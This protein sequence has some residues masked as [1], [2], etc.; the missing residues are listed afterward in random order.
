MKKTIT[1]NEFVRAFDDMN[2]EDQFTPYAREALFDYLE[3]LEQ[4]CGVPEIELDVIALCCEYTQYKNIE[5]YNIAYGSDFQ[6]FDELQDSGDVDT[7][8]KVG[9]GAIVD[10]H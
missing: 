5:E 1:K 3:E 10:N 4:V 6:N 8:I 9:A 2:R 7:V